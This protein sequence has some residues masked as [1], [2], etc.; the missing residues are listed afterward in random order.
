MANE[1]AKGKIHKL[2]VG[3][4]KKTYYTVGQYHDIIDATI[5]EIIHDS[6]FQIQTGG[7]KYLV[8]VENKKD[9]ARWVWAEPENFPFLP[10]YA[11]P[12]G[13]PDNIE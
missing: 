2:F 8:V 11:K 3:E 12:T 10:Q 13:A 5:V 4:D 9:K 7:T 6:N 1:Y